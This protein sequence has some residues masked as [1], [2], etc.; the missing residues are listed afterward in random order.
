[1]KNIC[2]SFDGTEVLKNFSC[3]FSEGKLNLLEGESGSG[4]T[5]VL[6]LLM[7]IL[8]ADDGTIEGIENKRT[9]AVFQEDRLLLNMSVSVNINLVLE[10]K[11]SDEEIEKYLKELNVEAAAS[12]KAGN[13][14]GGMKRRAAVLRAVLAKPDILVLDEA[15]SG[16]DFENA[17]KTIK[18]ILE[19]MKG[20]TII[21]AT[22]REELFEGIAYS[23]VTCKI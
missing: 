7:G 14:S 1:M 22:H 23:K 9:R 15:L 17:E 18:F 20:K 6:K 10:K 2:K 21:A 5:T 8:K 16:V 12:E 13:L 19:N 3:V 4:K 11:I